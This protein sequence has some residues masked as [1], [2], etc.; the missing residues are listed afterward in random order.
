MFVNAFELVR[1]YS[2][3]NLNQ[4]SNL[5]NAYNIRDRVDKSIPVKCNVSRRYVRIL[6]IIITIDQQRLTACD[7]V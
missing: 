6:R 4:K 7:C 2:E 1:R 3:S 5:I